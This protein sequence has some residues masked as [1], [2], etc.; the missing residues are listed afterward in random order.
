MKEKIIVR[1][2]EFNRG[3]DEGYFEAAYNS[4]LEKIFNKYK[5]YWYELM[6]VEDD[7]ER[8]MFEEYMY[9]DVEEGTFYV[10]GEE[11]FAFEGIAKARYT[12]DGEVDVYGF[13]KMKDWYGK[14]VEYSK[15]TYNP[16]WSNR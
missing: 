13:S 5:E 9:C 15:R 8:E 16:A 14:D 4:D 2:V 6:G 10:G 1:G 3:Y 11:G 7:E 12:V